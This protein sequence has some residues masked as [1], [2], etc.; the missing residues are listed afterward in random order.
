MT[1]ASLGKYPCSPK[2]GRTS[3]RF[4]SKPSRGRSM[5]LPA[6]GAA[7]PTCGR[8]WSGSS[9]KAG[10]EPWAKL[11]Q[12]LRSTRETELAETYPIHVV[13]AWIGNT[14]AVAA[15]HYLQVTDADFDRA[16]EGGAES[17]APGGEKAAQN[18]AKPSSADSRHPPRNAQSPGKP[19]LMSM[20]W[21]TLAKRGKMGK[22]PDKGSNLGPSG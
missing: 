16:S 19:R 2:C 6:T 18:P 12:N 10:L 5:S 3:K 20:R 17:G 7:T 15:K 22:L 11:F 14:A 13:C 21:P 8:N 9:D 1:A 4:G